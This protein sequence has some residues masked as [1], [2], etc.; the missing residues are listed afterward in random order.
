MDVPLKYIL[1]LVL[2]RQSISQA[3]AIVQ[4]DV[5]HVG[6]SKDANWVTVFFFFFALTP[7]RYFISFQ[8]GLTALMVAARSGNVAS[9]T[10]LAR[11]HAL[12]LNARDSVCFISI[13]NLR[14][15]YLQELS[16]ILRTHTRTHTTHAHTRAHTHTHTHKQRHTHA[17]CRN[18]SVCA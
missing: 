18:E 1:Y 7:H 17:A 16:S 5:N 9:I 6:R 3:L 12:P 10:M 4:S 8:D 11:E 13:T 2:F 14:G 15:E